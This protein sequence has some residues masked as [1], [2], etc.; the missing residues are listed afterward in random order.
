MPNPFRK[1]Q[2]NSCDSTYNQCWTRARIQKRKKKYTN[3]F[4]SDR[5][6]P[7]WQRKVTKTIAPDMKIKPMTSVNGTSQVILVWT[8]K[9]LPCR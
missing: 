3:P 6:Q 9:P 5:K 8:G 7:K 4:R 1:T 2:S